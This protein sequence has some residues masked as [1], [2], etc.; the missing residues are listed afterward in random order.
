MYNFMGPKALEELLEQKAL[1]FVIWQP[2][3]MMSHKDGKVAAT[4]VGRIGDGHGSEIDIEKI[5]DI[6]LHLHPTN[7]GVSYKKALRRKLMKCHFLL[8]HKLP[9]AAWINV[10]KALNAGS[11]QCFGLSRREESPVGLPVADGE[12]LVRAAESLVNIDICSLTG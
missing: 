2:Q 7:M 8:D 3:P 9:E 10:G 12:I 6:A 1:S 5:I 4:F 11:L